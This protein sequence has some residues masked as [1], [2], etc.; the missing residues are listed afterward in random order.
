MAPTAKMLTPEEI[1][2]AAVNTNAFTEEGFIFLGIA[3]FITLL[4]TYARWSMVG[5]KKFQPD[6]YLV[7]FAFVSIPF[8]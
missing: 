7:W 3:L 5:F 6:D 4:R 1:E 2:T 8:A